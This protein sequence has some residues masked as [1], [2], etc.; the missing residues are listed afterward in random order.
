MTAK[1]L[2]EAVRDFDLFTGLWWPLRD[3]P[4]APERQ[5][6]WLVARLYGVFP[7]RHVQHANN[8][9][10]LMLGRLEKALPNRFERE[11][12]RRR[13][14]AL[15]QSSLSESEPHLRWALSGIREA[16]GRKQVEGVDW[17]RLLDDLRLWVRGPDR[18]DQDPR[19]RE[20]DVRDIWAEDYLNGVDS[21]KRR[22]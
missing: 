14:D 11:R 3:S 19:R 1:S 21:S 13:F 9:I 18:Q 12:F 17:V 2:N 5:S 6:A 7:L 16:L 22:S 15:L 20:L 4:R 8:H 10:A